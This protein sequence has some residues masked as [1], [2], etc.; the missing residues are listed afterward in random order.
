MTKTLAQ[1]SY[2]QRMKKEVLSIKEHRGSLK[3][4]IPGIDDELTELLKHGPQ[5]VANIK[6]TFPNK[7]I[8]K[9]RGQLSRGFKNGDLERD[10][11]QGRIAREAVYWL[12]Y[13]GYL[14]ATDK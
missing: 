12:S 1:Q 2:E 9:I 6:K 11:V 4:L 13:K 7:H 10:Y 3:T 5:L 8:G 14:L